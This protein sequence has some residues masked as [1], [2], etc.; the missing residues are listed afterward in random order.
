VAR[1]NFVAQQRTE[2]I[3]WKCLT[4]CIL[5]IKFGRIRKQDLLLC[6]THHKMEEGSAFNS[7]AA[8][9]ADVTAFVDV[10]L[11]HCHTTWTS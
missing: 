7:T 6:R 9:E 1:G 5:T 10:N 11:Q 2:I 8:P 4:T 3:F